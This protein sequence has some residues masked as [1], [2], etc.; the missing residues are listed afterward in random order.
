MIPD[1]GEVV[2][3][4]AK[5]HMETAVEDMRS[6]FPLPDAIILYGGYAQGEGSWVHYPDGR[7]G[8]YNDYDFLVVTDGLAS[9]SKVDSLRTDLATKLG[10]RWIDI[11]V[12]R[13]KELAG[14]SPTI[15]NYDIKNGGKVLFGSSEILNQIREIDPSRFSLE[16]A[17]TLFHTRLYTFLGSLNKSGVDQVLTEDASRFFRNQMAK[18]VLSA[19]DVWLLLH[20]RYHSLYQERLRRVLSL[21]VYSPEE[22][23]LATWA[24]EE[25]LLPKAPMMNPS[26]VKELYFSVKAL[27]DRA[28]VTVLSSYFQKPISSVAELSKAYQYHWRTIGKRILFPF[29]KRSF[30]FKR[31]YLLHLAQ[32]HIW[33]ASL[34]G[35]EIDQSNLDRGVTLLRKLDSSFPTN[36]DWDSARCRVAKL[37]MTL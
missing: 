24:L 10:V 2:L 20:G 34:P 8:P 4:I 3:Q 23:E 6:I 25:K 1:H 22:S 11:T 27:F 36:A 31:R 32:I 5:S 15:R 29:V 30:R 28:M 33:G 16:E 7:W 13:R 37:R 19:S 18:A 21:N 35:G 9:P 26:D 12:C 17:L 14:F